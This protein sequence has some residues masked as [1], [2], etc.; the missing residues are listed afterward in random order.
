MDNVPQLW[1]AIAFN[2]RMG[3]R[4]AV[5]ESQVPILVC[6]HCAYDALLPCTWVVAVREELSGSRRNALPWRS[7]PYSRR[8]GRSC[9]SLVLSFSCWFLPL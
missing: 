3:W 5:I 9:V 4:V 2:N 1:R 7:L 8:R 6:N